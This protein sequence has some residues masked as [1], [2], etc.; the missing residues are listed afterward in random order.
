LGTQKI[1]LHIDYKCSDCNFLHCG[2]VLLSYLMWHNIL[3]W[4]C[5]SKSAFRIFEAPDM[6]FAN[7]SGI[8][9]GQSW[10]ADII[11]IVIRCWN[12]KRLLETRLNH[13]SSSKYLLWN[14]SDA[15]IDGRH[16][17]AVAWVHREVR[18]SKDWKMWLQ[19]PRERKT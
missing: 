9:F 15:T 19:P 2:R 17:R 3:F 7:C 10:I 12:A 8:V 14:I 5:S 16:K 18:A 13:F 4:G 1:N 11:G 6:C